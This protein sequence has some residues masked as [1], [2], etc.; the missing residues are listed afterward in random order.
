M[1]QTF[2]NA[3]SAATGSLQDIQKSDQQR[4]ESNASGQQNIPG[5]AS[6]AQV[7]SKDPKDFDPRGGPGSESQKPIQ[8]PVV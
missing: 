6:R 4:Q 5:E 2:N 8:D 3:A 1:E 7:A